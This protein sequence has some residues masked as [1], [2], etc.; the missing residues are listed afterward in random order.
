MRERR[1]LRGDEARIRSFFS[2]PELLAL[3]DTASQAE[4]IHCYAATAHLVGEADLRSEELKE[5]HEAILNAT[6]SG[7]AQ[8][9][10][11][12]QLCLW[13]ELRGSIELNARVSTTPCGFSNFIPQLAR[14]NGFHYT[15][16]Q[17]C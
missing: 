7:I 10:S 1:S 14:W 6:E 5:W 17:S 13:L 11:E 12:N 3:P 8:P 15:F 9:A 2:D 16:I 4:T